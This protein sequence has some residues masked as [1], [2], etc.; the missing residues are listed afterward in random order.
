MVQGL[1]FRVRISKKK[2]GLGLMVQGS[3]LSFRVQGLNFE[4][5]LFEKKKFIFL[6]FYLFKYLFIKYLDLRYLVNYTYLRV[7]LEIYT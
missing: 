3:E 6:D 2:Q 1:G 5:V 7:I 4:I